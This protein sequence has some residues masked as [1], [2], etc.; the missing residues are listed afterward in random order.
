MPALLTFDTWITRFTSEEYSLLRHRMRGVQ[1][2]GPGISKR[3]DIATA[4][5]EVDLGD[6]IMPQFAEQ[7]VRQSIISSARAP[8]IFSLDGTV[9]H[10][11]DAGE[12]PIGPQGPQGV[13]GEAGPAGPPGPAGPQGE[14]GTATAGPAG[15]AG[16][17]GEP[18]DVGPEGAVG[19]QG[20]PGQDSTVP[21]PPGPAGQDGP[22]GEVGQAGTPGLPGPVGPQG[23]E[24]AEGP[25]GADGPQGPKG[26]QGD[27]GLKGDPG[28]TGAQ[29]VPGPQGPAGADSTVPGPQGPQGIQGEPG[30]SSNL[31]D[32]SYNGSIVSPPAG[33]QV[34]LN[35]ADQ[36]STTVLFISP[37]TAPGNDASILLRVVTTG[38]TIL[39]QDKDNAARFQSFNVAAPAIDTGTFFE[40]PVAWAKGGELLPAGQRVFLLLSSAG[41]PGPQGPQGE[42]G[43]QG[44][45]GPAGADSIV[46][47]PQGAQGPTGSQ[48]SQGDP[49][50][51]GPAGPQGEPG[52][53][54][55]QGPEGIQGAQGAAGTGVVMKGAVPTQGDLPAG[56]QGDAYLVQADDSLWIYDGTQWVSGG[57]I[58]G[59]PGA[60]GPA[61]AQ[62]VAGPAGGEGAQ[63]PQGVQGDVGPQGIQG[64]QGPKGDTGAQG[65][66]AS[67]VGVI[68]GSNA[69]AGEIGEVLSTSI[70]TG[71][72]MMSGTA[73][74]IGS[75]SLPPGDYDVYGQVIFNAGTNLTVMAAAISLT[76]NT[77][78][79]AA[80]LAG[81][82]GAMQQLRATFAS[83][84]AEFLQTGVT[85]VNVSA[86]T[87]VY[88]VG[89]ITGT[90]SWTCTGFIRARRVR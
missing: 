42:P 18:G 39:L 45:Q 3:W 68:D 13:P 19:A 69:A 73:K 85:R 75:R 12:G 84:A 35:A 21:G 37:V 56:T 16:P 66:A 67:K 28:D 5:N 86:T 46:P 2:M 65:A 43:P 82:T 36:V 81:G 1:F 52:Q 83:S 50:S 77:L 31:L 27:P 57:S 89:M 7:L 58:Q 54:G 51:V 53:Q 15:P 22:Q 9:D 10:I 55:P 6:P 61:G 63:G 8:I 49:G 78:P 34:R 30:Q 79:T 74:D 24:G 23:S 80:Q 33:G 38:D 48:G 26:D 11:P 76:S 62:G 4:T 40:V 71:V 17:K 90:G 41:V 64:V 20:S 87:T 60:Q 29:G 25:R 88:L 59:P 72:A 47:G 70:T 44:E 14:P 32:Y